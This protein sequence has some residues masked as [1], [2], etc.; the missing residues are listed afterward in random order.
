[1]RTLATPLGSFW[2]DDA[3]ASDTRVG[4]SDVTV[5]ENLGPNSTYAWSLD[6]EEALLGAASDVGAR[7]ELLVPGGWRLSPG[8]A[9]RGFLQALEERA[10]TGK[11]SGRLTEPRG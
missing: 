10:A 5:A 9:L 4:V 6:Q 1:M 7:L 11:R 8:G 2:I 3:S